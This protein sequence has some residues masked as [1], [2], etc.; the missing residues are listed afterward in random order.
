[1][2]HSPLFALAAVVV[3]GLVSQW[4]AWLLRLPAILLL[5]VAGFLLG[6]VTGFVHPDQLFGS[7]LF[8]IVSIAVALILFE[9]GLMLRFSRIA[10]VRNVVVR[11]VTAGVALTWVTATFCAWL[12]LDFRLDL[13]LLLGAVLVVTGP[14]VIIPLLRHVRPKPRIGA[15]VRWEGIINDPIGAVL[16]VLV[17]E[18]IL[19]GGFQAMSMNLLSGLGLTVVAGTGTAVVGAVA[20]IVALKRHWIP[21]FLESPMTLALVISV[22]AAS[23]AI[24][25]ESGLFAVTLMGII[26]ANQSLVKVGH[27]VEFKENLRVLLISTL[28]VVLAAR[29]DIAT[30][31]QLSIESALFLVAL[32][33]V[34]RPLSIFVSTIGT[35][36]TWRDKLFVSM[37]APRG[38][39]AAAIASVF[40]FELSE[41]G[42]PQADRLLSETFLVI[43][44]TVAFYGLMARPLA[45]L[46]G[47]AQ[48]DAQGVVLAGSHPWSIAIGQ[49]LNNL[50]YEVEILA[51]DPSDVDAA[52]HAGLEAQEGSAASHEVVE[53]LDLTGFGKFVALSAT[54]EVNLLSSTEFSE[55][56]GSENVFR[57]ANRN[58][59][60]E[61]DEEPAVA[62]RRGRVLFGE[63]IDYDDLEGFFRRGGE[64]RTVDV[65]EPEAFERYLASREEAFPMFY[66]RNDQLFVCSNDTEFVPQTKD[67]V[68]CAVRDGTS[69]EKID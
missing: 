4:L 7:S 25:E 67:T 43:T 30:V 16:A 10:E 11:M 3:A 34:V 13:A 62:K 33:V 22:F 35:D 60:E 40:A 53:E 6:P 68:I 45:S 37:M 49:A 65:T 23:N 27:I 17:F 14:T 12:I 26:L 69:P 31:E 52:R 66:V 51:Q 1:M 57:L 29:I 59:A 48:E 36:L 8:P 42:V 55:A 56:F 46:L 54:D 9:G 50:G 64:V 38:I 19:A 24:Q 5:L 18:G 21:D 15:L 63:P 32:I 20:L 61:T 58:R 44:G 2:G 39:V 28:F 47:L 41:H